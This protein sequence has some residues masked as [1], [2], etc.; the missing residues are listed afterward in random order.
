ML[1]EP[2]AAHWDREPCGTIFARDQTCRGTQWGTPYIPPPA[3]G[4]LSSFVSTVPQLHFTSLSSSGGSSS[5]SQASQQFTRV[6]K[7]MP[8]WQTKRQY[9]PDCWQSK[10]GKGKAQQFGFCTAPHWPAAEFVLYFV[11]CYWSILKDDGGGGVDL[12]L[13]LGVK[14]PCLS[15]PA[16]EREFS[17]WPEQ[18]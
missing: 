12:D 8:S 17:V 18:Q 16:P 3:L 7:G 15:C 6:S 4:M 9:H 1:F 10:G 14:S 11:H 13:K 5:S 2:P